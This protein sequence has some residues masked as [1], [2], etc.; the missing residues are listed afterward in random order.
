MRFVLYQH[1]LTHM[2]GYMCA[3]LPMMLK[4]SMPL[5]RA[6]PTAAAKEDPKVDAAVTTTRRTTG[7][8][9]SYSECSRWRCVGSG[10][11]KQQQKYRDVPTRTSQYWTCVSSRRFL[12]HKII[13]I[14]Y[15]QIIIE[16]DQQTNTHLFH[17]PYI[18]GIQYHEENQ[19][20][21]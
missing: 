17:R 9:Q 15:V 10:V 18:Q 11:I 3:I 14:I 12:F 4:L 16:N 1:N 6:Q 21:N 5:S 19:K 8:D 13:F 20:E 7:I 2:W